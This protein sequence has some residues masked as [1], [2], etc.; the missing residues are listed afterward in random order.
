MHGGAVLV[1][2]HFSG[3]LGGFDGIDVEFIDK[4]FVIPGGHRVAQF[5]WISDDVVGHADLFTIIE[6]G[7][8]AQGQHQG[9]VDAGKFG[10]VQAIAEAG[11][12]A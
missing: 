11:V 7:R 10:V 9:G 6:E 5:G 3:A 1:A 8:A 4:L 12:D 2:G